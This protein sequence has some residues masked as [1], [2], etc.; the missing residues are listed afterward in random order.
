MKFLKESLKESF[1]K[2]VRAHFECETCFLKYYQDTD[3]DYFEDEEDFNN[4][5]DD[6]YLECPRCDTEN[7]AS[8]AEVEPEEFT[9]EEHEYDYKDC[10]WD[11]EYDDGVEYDEDND[12]WYF[13]DD[14]DYD[15]LDE[16]LLNEKQIKMFYAD[17]DDM[18]VGKKIKLAQDVYYCDI[19]QLIDFAF[20]FIEEDATREEQEK[21]AKDIYGFEVRGDE[22]WIPK[23]AV[24]V[25]VSRSGGGVPGWPDFKIK[26][27][28]DC[29][30]LSDY[31][32]IKIYGKEKSED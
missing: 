28:K 26:G 11:T 3:E 32:G 13:A 19:D 7:R 14:D 4:V 20:D 8:Y 17:S 31:D 22:L 2:K 9:V 1:G 27:K 18:K 23:D 21:C 10:G 5:M 15:D 6:S 30:T 25:L 24:L 12:E 29:F 16:S